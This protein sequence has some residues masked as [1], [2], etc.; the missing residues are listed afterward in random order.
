MALEISGERLHAILIQLMTNIKVILIWT[1]SFYFITLGY[2]L[3]RSDLLVLC[4][5]PHSLIFVD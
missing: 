2:M 5:Y 4:F 1:S 3:Y